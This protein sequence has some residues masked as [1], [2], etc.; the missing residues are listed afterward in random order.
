MRQ[1]TNTSLYTVGEHIFI[2]YV[3]PSDNMP[4]VRCKLFSLSIG[5]LFSKK[6]GYLSSQ[7]TIQGDG[8]GRLIV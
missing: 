6:R 2:G 5:A 3:F 4:Y 8:D 7:Q 1:D